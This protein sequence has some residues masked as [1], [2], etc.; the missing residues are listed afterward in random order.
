MAFNELLANRIRVALARRRGVSEKKMFGGVAFL[1]NGH[2]FCGVNRDDVV[3]RV[4]PDAW[5]KALSRKHARPMD[6]TG[7]P[8]S[9]YVY[10]APPGVRTAASLKTWVDQGLR[11]ARTLPPR[12]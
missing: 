7:R 5:A 8:L 1:A 4:G 10:V 9:G 2:M 12:T 11:F 3:V 6:F